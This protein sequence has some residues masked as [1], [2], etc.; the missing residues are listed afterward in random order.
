MIHDSPTTN[1]VACNILTL[2]ALLTEETIKYQIRDGGDYLFIILSSD[3]FILLY[4][5]CV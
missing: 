3:S 2:E 4:S 1:L 5:I